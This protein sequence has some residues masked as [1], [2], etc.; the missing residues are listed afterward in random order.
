MLIFSFSR[1]DPF[2]DA[3]YA[4]VGTT[5][6]I[7]EVLEGGINHSMRMKAIG[8]QRFKLLE[9]KQDAEGYFK[10]LNFYNFCLL[11]NLVFN[12]TQ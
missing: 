7:Y 8:R 6:E 1:S 9:T 5:A 3:T 4:D 11:K 12:G 2:A 10:K